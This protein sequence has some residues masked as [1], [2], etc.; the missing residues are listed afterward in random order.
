MVVIAVVCCSDH[1]C[2]E[3][4]EWPRL[5]S[6]SYSNICRCQCRDKSDFSLQLYSPSN[7]RFCK[8]G[9]EKNAGGTA[10]FVTPLWHVEG[11]IATQQIE[12]NQAYP[13]FENSLSGT[14]A[15]GF[16][17]LQSGHSLTFRNVKVD[18]AGQYYGDKTLGGVRPREKKYHFHL[19]HHN[20][21]SFVGKPKDLAVH[22]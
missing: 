11:V 18:D 10:R 9:V 20:K 2:D 22:V 14:L 5:F 7:C 16:P 6:D 8:R 12:V 15:V 21:N 13:E 17:A 19:G 1:L 3:Q 4:C